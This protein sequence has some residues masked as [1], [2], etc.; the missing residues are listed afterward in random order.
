MWNWIVHLCLVSSPFPDRGGC[1]S[2][3]L[4][5]PILKRQGT[6]THPDTWSRP[7]GTCICSTCWDQFSS[8][9]VVI[10]PDYALRISL[11]TFSILLSDVVVVQSARV[12]EHSRSPLSLWFLVQGCCYSDRCP[13]LG[14]WCH[15]SCFQM[16]GPSHT[17]P[18]VVDISGIGFYSDMWFYSIVYLMLV[19]CTAWL[20][21]HLG[22]GPAMAELLDVIVDDILVILIWKKFYLRGTF[23]LFVFVP[24]VCGHRLLLS[25][26]THS[27]ELENIRWCFKNN[28]STLKTTTSRCSSFL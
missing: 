15:P 25:F 13:P 9:L 10:L 11:G 26:L 5:F 17:C 24:Y 2:S 22:L 3:T 7:F 16:V 27:I 4:N 23:A 18:D 21:S 19:L 20:L 1:L 12:F 6:L 8:E 14:V 28:F